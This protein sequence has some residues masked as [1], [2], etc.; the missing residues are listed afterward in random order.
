VNKV[1]KDIVMAIPLDPQLVKRVTAIDA[2]ILKVISEALDMWLKEKQRWLNC[3]FTG[4]F[5]S[6]VHSACNECSVVSG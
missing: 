6:N 1:K 3:P 2:D 4:I 5:C